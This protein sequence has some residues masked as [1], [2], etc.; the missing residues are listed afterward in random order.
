MIEYRGPLRADRELECVTSK[1][2]RVAHEF[3][4]RRNRVSPSLCSM[5]I[6]HCF[7]GLPSATRTQLTLLQ[8]TQCYSFVNARMM[9]TPLVSGVRPNLLAMLCFFLKRRTVSADLL[10]A[11]AIS[12]TE[13]HRSG[14]ILNDPTVSAD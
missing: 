10:N 14:S 13:Y 4:G 9:S 2:L 6:A 3:T 7:A 5:L 8:P 1:S 11:C 12:E